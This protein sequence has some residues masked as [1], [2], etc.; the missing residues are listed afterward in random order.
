MFGFSLRLD[1]LHDA[2]EADYLIYSNV[3]IEL[4]TS[5]ADT[6]AN[7]EGKPMWVRNQR[8]SWHGVDFAYHSDLDIRAY[9]LNYYRALAAVNESVGRLLEWIDR[10]GVAQ[11]TIVVF[12]GDNGFLF[13]EHGLIDS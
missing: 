5:A 8:N 13:G 11:N 4:P 7:Y 6:P 12:M 9:K 10:E 1:R 2:V 3:D